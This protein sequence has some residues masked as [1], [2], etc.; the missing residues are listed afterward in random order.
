MR[1]EIIHQVLIYLKQ[2]NSLYCHT[3]IALE[4][5]PND[6]LSLSEDIDNHREFYKTDTLE[7]D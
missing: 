6:L 5:I 4:N 2:T 1:A 7:E 3:G